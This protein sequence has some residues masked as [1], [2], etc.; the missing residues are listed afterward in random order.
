M[1]H[2]HKLKTLKSN[3]SNQTRSRQARDFRTSFEFTKGKLL[4][5]ILIPTVNWP[6]PDLTFIWL[7]PDLTL[8]SPYLGDFKLVCFVVTWEER[9]VWCCARVFTDPRPDAAVTWGPGSLHR[10]S[11]MGSLHHKMHIRCTKHLSD[12]DHTGQEE[13]CPE[14]IVS[15]A[16]A[17]SQPQLRATC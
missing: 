5:E 9:Y 10:T 3:G 15:C 17:L 13:K 4:S 2:S 8:T 14:L 16:G 12:T 11:V 7:S 1:T 6:V